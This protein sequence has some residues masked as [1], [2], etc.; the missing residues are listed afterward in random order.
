MKTNDYYIVFREHAKDRG[1]KMIIDEP[2]TPY[3]DHEIIEEDDINLTSEDNSEDK[4]KVDQLLE[5][6]SSNR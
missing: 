4:I 3:N 2:K 1:N 6:A 5:Q